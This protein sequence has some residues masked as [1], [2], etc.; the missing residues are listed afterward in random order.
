MTTERFQLKLHVNKHTA[1]NFST[2]TQRENVL[3]FFL[4][5]KVFLCENQ[6]E[7]NRGGAER[8]KED[9]GGGEQ[10]GGG[11]PSRALTLD[12]GGNVNKL[13]HHT[14]QLRLNDWDFFRGVF[15]FSDKC[16]GGKAQ[17]HTVL[18]FQSA[19]FSG[20]QMLTLTTKKNYDALHITVVHFEAMHYC[21][22]CIL[23]F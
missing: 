14:A 10:G 1:H 7:Q 2:E 20:N 3:S 6:L 8:R 11:G 12:S 4:Q 19:T 23:F 21:K 9:G 16:F 13:T 17:N 18:T 22:A 5:W 15:W